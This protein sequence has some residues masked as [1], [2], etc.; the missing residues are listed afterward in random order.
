MS[1]FAS[2]E[3]S[4]NL[5][6]AAAALDIRGKRA[7]PGVFCSTSRGPPRTMPSERVRAVR[8]EIGECQWCGQRTHELMP[9]PDGFGEG[10]GTGRRDV[11]GSTSSF[12]GSY[13]DATGSQVHMMGAQ[14]SSAEIQQHCEGPKVRPLRA[15]DPSSAIMGAVEWMAGGNTADANGY[16]DVEG[17]R[18]RAGNPLTVPNVVDD[19]TCL[20]CFPDTGARMAPGG[21]DP[22]RLPT[23]ALR[24]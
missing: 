15:S 23:D 17:T 19:G 8:A 3:R 11:E 1:S 9:V 10:G 22:R 24:V 20:H 2:S 18:Y 4:F 5:G 7:I 21:A 13:Y 6:M 12:M 16:Q 14:G